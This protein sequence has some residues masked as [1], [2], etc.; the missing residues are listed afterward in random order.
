MHE[1]EFDASNL[2]HMN[3]ARSLFCDF[4]LVITLGSEIS[5][6]PAM[7]D[8]NTCFRS[9]NVSDIK[10]VHKTYWYLCGIASHGQLKLMNGVLL[11]SHHKKLNID[12][13]SAV[14]ICNFN[15]GQLLAPKSCNSNKHRCFAVNFVAKINLNGTCVCWPASSWWDKIW[16]IKFNQSGPT[17]KKSHRP[18]LKI[19]K[20]TILRSF[21]YLLYPPIANDARYK[22]IY[23]AFSIFIL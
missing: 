16:R 21:D 13:Y 11:S 17:Y 19:S 1:E 22:R 9:K 7:Y 8:Y 12:C 23:G 2:H 15:S 14:F 5:S 20:S 10:I 6:Q 18:R 4:N 3:A